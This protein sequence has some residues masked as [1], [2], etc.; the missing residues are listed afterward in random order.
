MRQFI[1][2]ACV[3]D[4][5]NKL[6][7]VND[8]IN[9]QFQSFQNSAMQINN[10]WNGR[11]AEQAKTKL[12]E[13]IQGGEARST[14]LENYIRMLSQQVDSGYESAETANTSLADQFK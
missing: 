13:L 4:S 6:R 8:R 12:Q 10:S 14:V 11:A 9:R 1:D 3:S 7:T 5:A 2:T